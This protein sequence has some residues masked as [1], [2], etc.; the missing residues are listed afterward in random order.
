MTKLLTSSRGCHG[1]YVCISLVL[2][3]P[4][5]F[6]KIQNLFILVW[7]RYTNSSRRFIHLFDHE[8]PESK[9][10]VRKIYFHGLLLRQLI[11]LSVKVC[12]RNIF[13]QLHL[14]QVEI[15]GVVVLSEFLFQVPMLVLTTIFVLMATPD[16]HL[17]VKH[18]Y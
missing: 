6:L 10:F 12:F 15:L 18:C 9:T 1:G 14:S 17:S 7:H 5:T 13:E 8:K 2:W 3:V 16:S 11:L 4:E